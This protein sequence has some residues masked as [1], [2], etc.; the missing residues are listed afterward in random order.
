[1]IRRITAVLLGILL[2][3]TIPQGAFSALGTDQAERKIT[4]REDNI[5]GNHYDYVNSVNRSFF[6]KTADGYLRLYGTDNGTVFVE[7]Y[8]ED[9]EFLKNA[10]VPSGLPIFGGFYENDSHY[11]VLTGQT[12]MGEE[13]NKE[14]YRLTKFDKEWHQLGSVGIKNAC[15]TIPFQGGCDFAQYNH[16]LI[17]RTARQM[18]R[19]H[20]QYHQS[21]ITLR[22]DVDA[23]KE[24]PSVYGASLLGS[25]GYASHSFNQFVAVDTDGTVVC[26]DHA[27]ANP[28]V[29]LLGKFR[30]KADTDFLDGGFQ[31]YHAI[32]I[33]RY[34][35]DD[36]DN[37]TGAN[38]GGLAISNTAYLTVGSSIEQAD[39]Y[40]TNESR[41]V[42]L[43]VT[44]KDDFS[45]NSTKTI[46][47]SDFVKSDHKCASNPHLV[48]LSD[49][50]FLIMWDEHNGSRLA[51]GSGK[52]I[53]DNPGS[54]TTMKYVF[55]DGNGNL[56]MASSGSENIHAIGDARFQIHSAPQE[57]QVFISGDQP[58]VTD[59]G[60]LWHF[61]NE[62]TID[63]VAEMDFDGNFTLHK[64]IIPKDVLTYPINMYT[65]DT[66]LRT[67]D[68]IPES[69]TLN[70]DNLFDY[71]GV[72]KNGY[73]LKCGEDFIL[74]DEDAPFTAEYENGYLKR[75]GPSILT[76]YGK[77]YVG[78][79]GIT[80]KYYSSPFSCGKSVYT[81]FDKNTGDVPLW[82]E[83]GV[84]L[85]YAVT[86]GVGCHIYRK[87][88]G[89]EYEKIGSVAGRGG[90]Y[91]Y[92]ATAQRGKHYW[93]TAREYTFDKDGN[94]IL[95][96]PLNAKTPDSPVVSAEPTFDGF[97]LSWDALNGAEKYAVY[98]YDIEK[99]RIKHPALAI[100]TDCNY[101]FRVTGYQV[102]KRYAVV[103]VD[104]QQEEL[105]IPEK[106]RY[107]P[108][109]LTPT[110][111]LNNAP[112]I[113]RFEFREDGLYIEWAPNVFAD[114]YEVL[115]DKLY[116]S[117]KENHL[118]IKNVYNNES[119]DI[120]VVAKR[121]GSK[122][123]QVPGRR[124]TYIA[125]GTDDWVF[126]TQFYSAQI[127]MATFTKWLGDSDQVTVPGNVLG[128]D[129]VLLSNTF[130][131]HPQLKRV[132]LS[133]N[134]SMLENAFQGCTALNSISLPE[135][136]GAVFGKCFAGCTGLRSVVFEAGNTL[137][138]LPE[139]AFEGCS[140]LTIY[141]YGT[142]SGA[143]DIANQFGFSYVDLEQCPS[144][145][146]DGNGV[147]DLIDATAI[148]YHLADMYVP[149]ENAVLMVGDTDGNGILEIPDATY[150]QRQIADIEMPSVPD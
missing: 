133:D 97:R 11:Y 4:Y 72:Y 137:S 108:C 48:K 21:N 40:Q 63:A 87:E 5:E 134:T 148:Q 98:E 25:I 107:S 18:Y 84:R 74:A 50:R 34:E 86:R 32:P 78:I 64:D 53:Y 103:A 136:V 104:P 118:L 30:N 149:V 142:D 114:N 23:M 143:Y 109:G 122:Q 58:I 55:V 24:E 126:Q 117:I 46:W 90:E 68:P 3:I 43:S 146:A 2:T 9:F 82:T 45:E 76:A 73:E 38:V 130:C 14:V 28:R 8:N 16:H 41:N 85:R 26:L 92:D 19:S 35:G 49:D 13:L 131:N 79:A 140:D 7:Y 144:G 116:R 110:L 66:V 80:D 119:T 33:I 81:A 69:L 44:P 20:N 106:C 15:T 132:I 42:Y 71:I 123:I 47:F 135:S 99:D 91:F 54:P 121:S 37:T 88:D 141:G 70:K 138:Q 60:V 129:E 65:A 12:N 100:T 1:M 56:D 94:E 31:N 29:A 57:L 102:D 61:S 10:V 96:E 52:I 59:R 62:D 101:E 120:Y 75:I 115:Y 6:R 127:G 83:D 95:S 93:Y 147:V 67:F 27:D 77:S 89:G 105:V 51:D 111:T 113:T 36:G 112:E 22:F 124:V 150:I 128:V 145:D 139:D 125:P 39:D 17:V